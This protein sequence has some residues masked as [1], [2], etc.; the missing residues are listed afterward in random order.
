M[1]LLSGFKNIDCAG[2]DSWLLYPGNR[3]R[4]Y[5][6]SSNPELINEHIEN[7]SEIPDFLKIA[8]NNA[9]I[10]VYT[11]KYYKSRYKQIKNLTSNK[12]LFYIPERDRKNYMTLNDLKIW[13][14][15]ENLNF[16]CGYEVLKR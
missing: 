1:A 2:F 6:R 9:K 8:L 11:Y 13:E 12:N 5:S 3:L 15:H 10:S 7:V 4:W 16:P 14:K